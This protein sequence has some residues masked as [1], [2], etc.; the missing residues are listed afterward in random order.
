MLTNLFL[1]LIMVPIMFL[2]VFVGITRGG[3]PFMGAA[4]SILAII[5]LVRMILDDMGVFP[6]PRIKCSKCGSKNTTKFL[7]KPGIA[8]SGYKCR[9]NDCS[10]IDILAM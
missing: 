8:I 6:E 2:G 3:M 10:N 5:F 4:I 9:C 7:W 1:L